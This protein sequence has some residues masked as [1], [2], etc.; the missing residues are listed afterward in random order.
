ML[1]EYVVIGHKQAGA[2]HLV[3]S[4]HLQRVGVSFDER[5]YGELFE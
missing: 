2:A 4:H 5:E 1:V 3:G